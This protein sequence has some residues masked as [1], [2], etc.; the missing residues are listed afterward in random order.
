MTSELAKLLRLVLD[1]ERG[2]RGDAVAERILDAALELAAASGL[3]RLTMDEVARRAGVGR[4]TVYR[5]FASRTALIDALTIRECRYCLAQIED[6]ID[7]DASASER[8]TGLFLATLGV[9]RRHPLLE[10]LGR[11]EPEA[12]LRELGRG[13]S[14][15]FRLVRDFLREL[16]LTGQRA[17]ELPAGDPE[18]MAELGIRL[19]AS[20]VLIPETAL[21]LEDEAAARAALA[22]L[23]A[24]LT[25]QRC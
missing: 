17:G 19:G 10:R 23:I 11:V 15:V 6:A 3:R 24:P 20:F 18:L 1:A 9:I 14:A 22:S 25:L 12:L 8:L 16:I 4:M 21:P 2:A 13:N 7:D 5:R